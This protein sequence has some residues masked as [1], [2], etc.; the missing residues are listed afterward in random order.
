MLQPLLSNQVLPPWLGI[1]TWAFL[2]LH[3]QRISSVAGTELRRPTAA[4]CI[5]AEQM[6]SY[7][8]YDTVVAILAPPRDCSIGLPI[9][10]NLKL[11]SSYKQRMEIFESRDQNT[12]FCPEN[13]Q[14]SQPSNL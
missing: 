1:P 4:C 3:P 14:H 6:M 8:P 10:K 2:I 7:Y 13:P 9:S 11:V 12:H 5:L